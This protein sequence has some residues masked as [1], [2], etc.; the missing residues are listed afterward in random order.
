MAYLQLL[1]PAEPTTTGMCARLSEG[2]RLAVDILEEGVLRILVMPVE[3]AR[4]DRTWC[5]RPDAKAPFQGRPRD[6]LAPFACPN[7]RQQDAGFTGGGFRVSMTGA[8]LALKVQRAT[9]GAVLL[10]DRPT[11]AWRRHRDALMHYELRASGTRHLGL[12]DASGPIDRSNRRVRCQQID[13]LGY[14]A[15]RSGPLYKHTPFLI[16]DEPDGPCSAQLYET[17]ADTDFDLGAEHS[18]YHAPYRYVQTAD[19]TIA[20]YLLDGPELRDVIPRLHG[21]VGHAPALPTWAFGFGFTSMHHADDADAQRV[22]HDFAIEARHRRMPIASIHFGSGYTAGADGR[23]Y[24]FTWNRSRFPDPEGLQRDLHALGYRTVAN[25][26][27]NL[28]AEHPDYAEL[29]KAGAFVNRNDGTPSTA[30]FWGGT[31]AALD[32][33]TTSARRFWRERLTRDVLRVGFD[34]VWNDNNEMEL[35]DDGAQ[36]AGDGRPLPAMDARPLLALLMTRASEAALRVERPD[37]APYCISRAGP[38]GIGAVAETWSGDNFTSWH[39]LRWNLAQSLSMSL[40]G[41]PLVGHDIGGFTGPRPGAELLLRWFQFMALHPRAVMNSWNTDGGGANTPWMHAEVE[42]EVRAILELRCRFLPTLTGALQRHLRTGHPLIAPPVYWWPDTPFEAAPT[43]F[44]LG[45][46]VL[47]APVVEDGA[48]VVAVHTP[49]GA[50]WI[51]FATG[52]AYEGGVVVELPAPRDRLPILVREGAALL[53][54]DAFD[55]NEPWR[56]TARALHVWPGAGSG[57]AESVIHPADAE[58]VQVAVSWTRKNVHVTASAAL[59]DAV[60]VV[61]HDPAR[62]RIDRQIA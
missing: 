14:D 47:V 32:F 40:S 35:V 55:G 43:S 57:N 28:L 13:A 31:G 34:G 44:M 26:K 10:E 19:D 18:N 21:L 36:L 6:D 12:G 60:E 15:E 4:V 33:T 45:P 51:D 30:Q 20:L 58:P 17:L 9:D 41:M 46:D 24:V 49:T 62:R 23:R 56:A 8:P 38:L 54:A 22:I 37:V 3:G 11:G 39:T 50:N 42:D 27:P 53:L 7:V 16:V 5:I 52:A 25:V 59:A 2:Y 48:R 1:G 61:S 29:A